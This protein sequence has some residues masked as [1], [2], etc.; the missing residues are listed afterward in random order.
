MGQKVGNFK[1]LCNLLTQKT[2][3]IWC[4]ALFIIFP[5]IAALLALIAITALIIDGLQEI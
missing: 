4:I 1:A 3:P 5:G 2:V